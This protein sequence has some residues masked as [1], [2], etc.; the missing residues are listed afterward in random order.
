MVVRI[1]DVGDRYYWFPVGVGT[2]Y[3]Y[4]GAAG[5]Q[6][7]YV[8]DPAEA[9]YPAVYTDS[10]GETLDASKH[11]YVLHF[12]NGT[13]PP[14]DAFWSTTM[15]DLEKRLMVP[16]DMKRYSIGDRTPG[17]KVNADG[18]LDIFIQ[19]D[20]PEQAFLDRLWILPDI[21]KAK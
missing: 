16:N 10:D 15:Y 9:Y 14:V 8:N 11:N 13:F 4:R 18:S 2:D 5:W 3:L 1:P 17:L 6:S 7:M 21:E 19:K 20:S 12:D